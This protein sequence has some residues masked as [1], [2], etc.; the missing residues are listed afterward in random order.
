[1][2]DYR[3]GLHDSRIVQ[4][5]QCFHE[6]LGE[7]DWQTFSSVFVVSQDIVW[8][9]HGNALATALRER[10]QP[11]LHYLLED[12]ESI[13][14]LTVFGQLHQWLADQKA[15]RKSLL[16]V[17]GGGVVGDL[18]GFVAATYMRGIRWVYL[19]TTLLSQQDASVGGKVAVNLPQGKNLVGRF[20]NPLMV[21][22]DTSVLSTLPGR[23]IHAGYMELLKHGMLAGPELYGDIAAMPDGITDWQEHGALLWRGLQV[24]MEIVN[25]DPYEKDRRRLLNLGHTFGHALESAFGYRNLLHGEAVGIGLLFAAALAEIMTG[26]I[27]WEELAGAILPRLPPLNLQAWDCDRLLDLTRLDKKGIAGRVSWIVPHRPGVVE[28][29]SGIDDSMLKAAY[30]ELMVRLEEC[31]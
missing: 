4:G 7:L 17:L 14:S 22:I 8:G 25:E 31:R 6:A 29:V 1:M 2:I 3:T 27:V 23:E 19:P 28:I 24:K 11:F 10:N 5:H 12:G 9:F 13:K 15:D 20:W 16:V 21:V 26:K 18:V 30:R